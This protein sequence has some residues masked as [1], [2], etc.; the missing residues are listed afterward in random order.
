MWTLNNI[1]HKTQRKQMTNMLEVKVTNTGGS[2]NG[3]DGRHRIRRVGELTHTPRG[4]VGETQIIRGVARR[5][6][7]EWGVVSRKH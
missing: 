1:N 5:E 3:G 7:K 6:G 4:R 2:V